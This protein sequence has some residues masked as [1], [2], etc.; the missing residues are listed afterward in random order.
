[1]TPAEF[2]AER[3]RTSQP[4]PMTV[5][6]TGGLIPTDDLR[7]DED[8]P[9]FL[10]APT[11]TP[12]EPRR[13]GRPI[14]QQLDRPEDEAAR[15]PEQESEEQE[16]VPSDVAGDDPDADRMLF[17]PRILNTFGT[18]LKGCFVAVTQ[19]GGKAGGWTTDNGTVD[20][21]VLRPR[22]TEKGE[23]ESREIKEGAADKLV[24]PAP[25]APA[26][27]RTPHVNVQVSRGGNVLKT[28][29]LYFRDI[30]ENADDPHYNGTRVIAEAGS[31]HASYDIVI[32]T[33]RPQD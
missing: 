25:P 31:D 9:E 20:L 6:H 17:R 30:P 7:E 4:V 18:P 22:R 16:T 11:E 5:A 1:M 32:D 8:A 28:T 29:R 12:P 19:D 27:D 10:A 23:K 24:A 21:L 15:P 3:R 33:G 14:R 26:P 2:L 13:G